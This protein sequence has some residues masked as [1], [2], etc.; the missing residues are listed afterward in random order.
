MGIYLRCHQIFC[1]ITCIATTSHGIQMVFVALGEDIPSLPDDKDTMSQTK[2]FQHPGELDMNKFLNGVVRDS[3]AWAPYYTKRNMD[4]NS[5]EYRAM[6]QAF[7]DWLSGSLNIGPRLCMYFAPY[8]CKAMMETVNMFY[9]EDKDLYG[10]LG[11][12][13]NRCDGI[14]RFHLE[15]VSA[16][17]T[18][19]VECNY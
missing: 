7:I 1:E 13:D 14:K 2:S 18:G 15:S 8:D 16:G 12:F 6:D 11:S 10:N 3:C 5:E 19:E 9:L 17:Y 4:V